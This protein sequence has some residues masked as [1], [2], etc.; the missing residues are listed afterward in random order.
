MFNNCKSLFYIIFVIIIIVLSLAGGHSHGV[1]S[2]GHAPPP[3]RG[4]RPSPAAVQMSRRASAPTAPGLTGLEIRGGRE[5][6][7][8]EETERQPRSVHFS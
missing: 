3:S 4:T 6:A 7:I 8:A 5:A 2:G 1:H